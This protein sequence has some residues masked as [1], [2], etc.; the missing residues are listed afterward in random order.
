MEVNAAVPDRQLST[1]DASG[2]EPGAPTVQASSSLASA[3][4]VEGGEG[5]ESKKR[6]R[7]VVLRAPSSVVKVG[8]E[9]H[10]QSRSGAVF[11]LWIVL[12]DCTGH[13]NLGSLTGSLDPH[14]ML[15]QCD[16]NIVLYVAG[17][18]FALLG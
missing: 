14:M 12:T 18:R 5:A 17:L 13:G 3:E 11:V 7:E 15:L 4:G 10:F 16:H 2:L 6:R 8:L 1:S 9:L